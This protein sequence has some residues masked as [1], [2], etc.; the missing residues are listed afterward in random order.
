MDIDE[1]PPTQDYPVDLPK[2]EYVEVQTSSG[3]SSSQSGGLGADAAAG[4]AA[5]GGAD[6]AHA[7][8]RPRDVLWRARSEFVCATPPNL[9]SHILAISVSLLLCSCDSGHSG[10][11]RESVAVCAMRFSNGVCPA[12]SREV[13]GHS[14]LPSALGDTHTDTSQHCTATLACR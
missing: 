11:E 10:V 2:Y 6:V 8:P 5:A 7:G 3:S 1:L 9:I 4:I 12:I 14:A 13:S